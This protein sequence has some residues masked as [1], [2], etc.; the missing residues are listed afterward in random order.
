MNFL[1]SGPVHNILLVKVLD[2]LDH[3]VKDDQ[4]LPFAQL[5]LPEQNRK[6]LVEETL[7]LLAIINFQC[8]VA[9]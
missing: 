7:Y 8:I 2:N 3:V 6:V 5:F 9:K 1:A 4:C